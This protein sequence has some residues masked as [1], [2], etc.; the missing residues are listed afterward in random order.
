MKKLIVNADDFGYYSAVN[1][2]IIESFERGLINSTTLMAIMPGAEEAFEL[3]HQHKIIDQIGVHLVLT[4]GTPITD[5]IKQVKSLVG[6]DGQFLKPGLRTLFLLDNH[7]KKL[8]YK[9]YA[10]QV[11]KVRKHGIPVNHVDTHHQI[12]DV[13]PIM[14]IIKRLIKDLNIPSMRILN[15]ME[16]GGSIYKSQYRKIANRFLKG[17]NAHFTEMMGN[18]TDFIHLA[19]YSAKT[20]SQKTVEVMVHPVY[21]EKQE[22]K[23]RLMGHLYDMNFQME[24]NTNYVV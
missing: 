22:L 18:R 11:Q 8:I 19:K 23:D 9:E 17:S 6:P 15:N 13:W 16:K 21:N 4:E 10:A 3:A 5:D 12:H 7:T 1:H 14:N 20:M 24:A 2:A